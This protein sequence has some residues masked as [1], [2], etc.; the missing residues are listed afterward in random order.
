MASIN[1]PA[2]P[3]KHTVIASCV[4]GSLLLLFYMGVF[5][6][7]P[8]S[9][10]EFKQKMLA[11]ISALLCA[12]FTFFFVGSLHVTVQLKNKW[13]K[14]AIQSGG[15]AAAFVL[16]LWWCNNPD[17]APVHRQKELATTPAVIQPATTIEQ[18]TK[19]DASSATIDKIQLYNK[20]VLIR[21]ILQPNHI[22]SIIRRIL[23]KLTKEKP[24]W[25]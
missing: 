9:L 21:K 11:I 3:S 18:I 4:F 2:P 7:A 10:P 19:G 17:F 16:I 25:L 6:F 14:I 1:L 22:F 20:I 12:L 5:A 24:S 8:D 15:G 13:S 23:S